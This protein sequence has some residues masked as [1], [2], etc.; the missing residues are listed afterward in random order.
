MKAY[1]FKSEFEKAVICM[2]VNNFRQ[3]GHTIKEIS[4]FSKLSI[5]QV[6]NLIVK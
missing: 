2:M 4:I 6:K 1:K 3:Q 5:S